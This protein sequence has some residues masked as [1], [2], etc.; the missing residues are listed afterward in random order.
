LLPVADDRAELLAL[1]ADIH[2]TVFA[3]SRDGDQPFQAMVITDSSDRDHA[4]RSAE[5]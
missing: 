1:V 2:D 5:H 4:Q 3:H